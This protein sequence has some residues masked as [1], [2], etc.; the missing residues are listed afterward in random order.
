MSILSSLSSYKVSRVSRSSVGTTSSYDADTKG[1]SGSSRAVAARLNQE[2]DELRWQPALWLWPSPSL[3]SV[4]HSVRLNP[5]QVLGE[6][7]SA[8]QS[9]YTQAGRVIVQALLPKL[10]LMSR[11]YPYPGVDHLVPALWIRL[12]RYPLA[13]RPTSIAANLVL[14][15]R[16]DVVAEVRPAPTPA[17]TAAGA[18]LTA[19]S[20]LATAR[21]LKLATPESLAIMEHVYVD[22][23]PNH[24]VADLHAISPA[25][26]RRRCSD[27]MQHLRANRELLAELALA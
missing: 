24:Q 12:T 13:R 4:L 25:A 22:G 27:T 14:D 15:A 8:C 16:K 23:L 5:D 7:I 19:R 11:S 3:D 10:I 21:L 9:G 2:W 26:V 17:I 1:A 20:V 18:E 6:L